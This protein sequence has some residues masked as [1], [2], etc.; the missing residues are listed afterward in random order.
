MSRATGVQAMLSILAH[1]PQTASLGILVTSTALAIGAR[2]PHLDPGRAVMTSQG[3]TN[4]KVGP[5]ALDLVRCGLTADEVFGALR[6]HDRWIDYRQLALITPTG[7]TEA[8]TGS[9]TVDWA[10]HLVGEGVIAMGNSLPDATPVE[11]MRDAFAA[12]RD[13]PLAERLLQAVERARDAM[14][15]ARTLNS[16][17]LMVHGGSREGARLD[18]RID[19]P[20]TPGDSPCAIADLRHLFELYKP[21]AEHYDTRSREP[22]NARPT[23][24]IS[25]ETPL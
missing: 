22:P 15:E 7:Q 23:A 12:A 8:F 10:G 11:A 5:L 9:M 21:L 6:Q 14:G 1:D 13:L 19:M 2:C 20:R 4:L 17:A 16:A 3:Y 18:L 25:E 24:A